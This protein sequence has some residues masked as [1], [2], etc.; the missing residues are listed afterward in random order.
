MEFKL[1]VTCDCGK[2]D[3]LILKRTTNIYEGKVY[4]DFSSI[5]DGKFKEDLFI[6]QQ[7]SP[8]EVVIECTSCGKEHNLTT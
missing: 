6:T 5:T 4:E 3:E 8:D 2:R 1:T 7:N